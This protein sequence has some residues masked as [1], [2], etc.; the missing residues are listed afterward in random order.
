MLVKSIPVTLETANIVPSGAIG[1]KP[2]GTYMKIPTAITMVLS[3]TKSREIPRLD[4]FGKN[5]INQLL[6]VMLLPNKRL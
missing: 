3:N 4:G 2:A 5:A 1:T 6:N